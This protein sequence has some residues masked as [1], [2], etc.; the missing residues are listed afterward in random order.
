MAC[1]VQWCPT[2]LFN[3]SLAPAAPGGPLPCSQVLNTQRSAIYK[4]RQQALMAKDLEN[5]YKDYAA[6]TMDD[7]LEANIPPGTPAAEWQPLLDPLAAKVKQYCVLLEDLTGDLLEEESAGDYEKLRA[8]LK[9]RALEAY[10]MR[11]EANKEMDETHNN[12]VQQFFLL[13]Q[14]DRLWKE[15]LQVVVRVHVA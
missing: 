15:H 14:T 12:E 3:K 1:L 13:S 7:I 5:T 10:E 4:S 8:Y 2:L 11:A 6:K 9:K